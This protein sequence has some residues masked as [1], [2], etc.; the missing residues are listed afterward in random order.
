[1]GLLLT[2]E[3]D[4]TRGDRGE[5]HNLEKWNSQGLVVA[6]PDP[7]CSKSVQGQWAREMVPFRT[8]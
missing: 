5:A 1:M 4:P 2:K 3:L 6:T 7:E 8:E